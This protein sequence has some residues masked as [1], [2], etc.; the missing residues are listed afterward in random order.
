MS[1]TPLGS[2][3]FTTDFKKLQIFDAAGIAWQLLHPL[4][5]NG[6]Q[7]VLMFVEKKFDNHT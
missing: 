5:S 7:R 6:T 4:F 3:S 1:A 2:A